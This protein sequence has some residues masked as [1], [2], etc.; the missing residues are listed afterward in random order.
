MVRT[1][2]RAG[3]A[4]I[5]QSPLACTGALERAVVA[6]PHC[7]GNLPCSRESR[8]GDASGKL[9]RFAS[10]SGAAAEGRHPPWRRSRSP[11]VE[12][13]LPDRDVLAGSVTRSEAMVALTR[14]SRPERVLLADVLHT[15]PNDMPY[16]VDVTSMAHG[17]EVRPLFLDRRVVE[18]ARPAGPREVEREGKALLKDVGGLLP[19]VSSRERKKRVRC[20]PRCSRWSA[21]VLVDDLTITPT[22]PLRP[23]I[24][25]SGEAAT[26]DP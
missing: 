10:L 20:W 3:I 21:E 18:P 9:D 17:L 7:G 15:L 14:A 26:P 25:G 6:L 2:S 4:S 8:W 5:R 11:E 23:T 16:K 24:A 1:R 12:D 19:S 13:L 22:T